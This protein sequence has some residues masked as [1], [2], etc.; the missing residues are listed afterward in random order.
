[1]PTTRHDEHTCVGQILDDAKV[2]FV[3]VVYTEGVGEDGER[4]RRPT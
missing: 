1:V 4:K 3:V 2:M